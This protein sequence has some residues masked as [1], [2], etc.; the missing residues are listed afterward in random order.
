MNATDEEVLLGYAPNLEEQENYVVGGNLPMDDFLD[1][2][3]DSSMESELFIPVTNAALEPLQV[4]DATPILKRV[5]GHMLMNQCGALLVRK[6]AQ[7]KGSRAQQAFL[8]RFVATTLG[9]CVPLV[10][11]EAVLFNSIFWKGLPTGDLLGAIPS[12]LLDWR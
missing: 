1:P 10:Y 6:N 5:S 3:S 12:A 11:A 7:I 8:Q 4:V 2:D 9:M